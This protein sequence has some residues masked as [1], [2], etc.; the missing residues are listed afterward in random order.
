MVWKPNK[1]LQITEIEEELYMAK[2]GNEKDKKRVLEMYPWSYEKQLILLPDFKG[3]QAPKEISLTRS[4]FWIQI[5]NLPL[6]SKTRETGWAIG[7]TL[8]DV[9]EV[10]VEDNGVQ[11]GKYLR[12]KVSI[13]VTKKLIRGKKVNIEGEENRW[14]LFKYERLLNFCNYCGMLSHDWKDCKATRE[15]DETLEQDNLQYGPWLRGE[16]VR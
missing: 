12:V 7:G 11:W 3:E 4:P 15:K 6:K 14:V 13:D 8:G 5:H 10:Y 2:F 1:G 16:I 9:L